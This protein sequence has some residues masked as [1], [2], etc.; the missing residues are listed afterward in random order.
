MLEHKGKQGMVPEIK[1]LP[2]L[3]GELQYIVAR[4]TRKLRNP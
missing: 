4:S 2:E 3:K 1:A